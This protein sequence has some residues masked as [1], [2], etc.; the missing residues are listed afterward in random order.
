ML[1]SLWYI[2]ASL[3]V[4]Y[5]AFQ[6]DGFI[7]SMKG[8]TVNVLQ[9]EETH[10]MKWKELV[11]A[12]IFRIQKEDIVLHDNHEVTYLKVLNGCIIAS[13]FVFVLLAVLFAYCSPKQN[14]PRNRVG[15]QGIAF[16][17]LAVPLL[18]YTLCARNGATIGKTKHDTAHHL[19]FLQ[20]SILVSSVG[21]T[22]ACVYFLDRYRRSIESPRKRR[23]A[24]VVINTYNLEIYQERGLI[25]SAMMIAFLLLTACLYLLLDYSFHSQTL[26]YATTV[27]FM[28]N[29]YRPKGKRNDI[30][31]VLNS[32]FGLGEWTAVTSILSFIMTTYISS[33]FNY[34][35]NHLHMDLIVARA[36]FLGCLVGACMDLSWIYGKVQKIFKLDMVTT[37]IFTRISFIVVTTVLAL[38]TTMSLHAQYDPRNWNHDEDNWM[39]ETFLRMCHGI[40]LPRSILWLLVFLFKCGDLK[41]CSLSFNVFQPTIQS[42]KALPHF[43]WLLY[44][45]LSI[46]I[47]APIAM[48]I[49]YRLQKLAVGGKS[50]K[51]W[52]VIARKY[53]HLVAI[54]LFVPPTVFAPAMMALSYAIATCVLVFVESV[55]VISAKKEKKEDKPEQSSIVNQFFEAFFDE[56]DISHVNGAFVITHLALVIG[57]AA[58]LWT[59]RTIHF[60]QES[61]IMPLI[62]IIVIGVGDAF[63]AVIGSLYGKTKWPHSKRTLEGSLAMLLSMISAEAIITYTLGYSFDE[64]SL[65]K[66]S[67]Y[68]YLP[69]SFLEAFTTETIDNLSLPVAAMILLNTSF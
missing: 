17:S 32:V 48:M 69:I 30:G 61:S 49:F 20:Y 63:G 1:E 56:K 54:V 2:F 10:Y 3:A 35:T 39:V 68:V 40:A 46:A 62:G 29:L 43:M 18:F 22:L 41:K 19:D 23:F 53:F 14:F 37:K 67:L 4:G 11:I 44:W 26:I 55:R 12:R 24:E 47:L 66:T 34:G 65:W 60:E 6:K 31:T 58:P 28:L 7:S 45:I 9:N 64:G 8:E 51:K 25:V 52:V 21:V 27:L 42:L 38:E 16:G 50:R 59:Y 5:K 15:M 57:C 13:I 36:G 33:N